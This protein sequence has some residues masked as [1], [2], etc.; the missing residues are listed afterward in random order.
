MSI[1][2]P[3]SPPPPRPA[4]ALETKETSKGS[5][6]TIIIIAAVVGVLILAGLIVG[7]IYLLRNPATAQTVRDVFIIFMALESMVIGAA[8]IALVVQ[9]A[10]LTNLLKNEIKP[11]LEATQE[12][13]NTVRGTAT[14][15]SE[16]LVDPVIKLN[17]YV[18]GLSKVVETLGSFGGIFRR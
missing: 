4:S 9:L 7:A 10:V 11:I 1:Q 14:F 18:A 15:L 8:L 13:A 17:A 12:T 5:S 16:N 6:R 2:P 3:P